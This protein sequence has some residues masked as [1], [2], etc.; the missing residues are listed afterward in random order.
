MTPAVVVL[1]V[2]SEI[3]QEAAHAN[4]AYAAIVR[5]RA[6]NRGAREKAGAALRA[7]KK[8]MVF[9]NWLAWL[10]ANCPQISE[11]TAQ[12]YMLVGRRWSKRPDTQRAADLSIHEALRLLAPVPKIRTSKLTVLPSQQPLFEELRGSE[13]VPPPIDD[14]GHL[15]PSATSALDE[16]Y[17]R[18]HGGKVI[19]FRGFSQGVSQG[20]GR[21]G[22]KSPKSA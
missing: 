15:P 5:A 16:A 17:Q 21:S 20:R 9:G 12:E 8:R 11:R 13:P 3:D 2:C 7:A 10:K 6:G 19:S 22:R 18:L 4:E 14:D 1:D